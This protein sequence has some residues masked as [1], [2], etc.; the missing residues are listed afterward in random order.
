MTEDFCG[1]GKLAALAALLAHDIATDFG[2][3]A[4]GAVAAPAV[5]PGGGSPAPNSE[6][7]A[8]GS[9]PSGVAGGVANGECPGTLPFGDAGDTGGDFASGALPTPLA[10]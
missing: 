3:T 6:G 5:P 7:N 1:G 9:L 4:D 10:G 2:G 8:A